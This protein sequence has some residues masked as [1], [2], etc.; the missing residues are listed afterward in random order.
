MKP[1]P[2]YLIAIVYLFPFSLASQEAIP[3]GNN[4]FELL[5]KPA[6]SNLVKRFEDYYDMEAKDISTHLK[7]S[8]GIEYKLKNDKVKK[9]ILHNSNG[10][11]SPYSSELPLGLRWNMTENEVIKLLGT[12]TA[13]LPYHYDKNLD[14]NPQY[15]GDEKRLTAIELKYTDYSANDKEKDDDALLALFLDDPTKFKYLKQGLVQPEKKSNGFDKSEFKNQLNDIIKLF[16]DKKSGQLKGD[17]LYE[18]KKELNSSKFY[19][20][21][22]PV[23]NVVKQYLEKKE[24]LDKLNY[25]IILDEIKSEKASPFPA[26]VLKKYNYWLAILKELLT[27]PWTFG[28]AEVYEEILD[29]GVTFENKTGQTTS[30]GFTYYKYPLVDLYIVYKNDHYLIELNIY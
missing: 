27:S 17:F 29:K 3:T 12:R 28:D 25:L 20:S 23:S 26:A 6:T 5:D 8:K 15:E 14:L 10:D 24:M 16:A 7:A 2:L 13:G 21:R 30:A 4:L 19:S 9:I 22:Q 1:L 18:I 11:W